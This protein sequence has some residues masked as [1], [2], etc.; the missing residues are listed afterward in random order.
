M[1]QSTLQGPGGNATADSNQGEPFKF[2]TPFVDCAQITIFTEVLSIPLDRDRQT[3]RPTCLRGELEI[4]C[5]IALNPTPSVN[6]IFQ[7]GI[8]TQVYAFNGSQSTTIARQTLSPFQN[9]MLLRFTEVDT[10]NRLSINCAAMVNGTYRAFT[11]AA[12]M[13]G[14]VSATAIVQASLLMWR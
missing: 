5:T 9:M 7:I 8:D 12:N 4:S 1:S 14:L 10:W 11:A 3:N 13:P 2:V 6:R